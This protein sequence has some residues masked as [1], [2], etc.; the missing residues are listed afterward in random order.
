MSRSGFSHGNTHFDSVGRGRNG[1][2][3]ALARVTAPVATMAISSDAL[4]P[5]YQQER[6]R[7]VLAS[8]GTCV[9]HTVIDSPQ[10]HDGFLLEFD[11]VGAAVSKFLARL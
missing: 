11:Q 5:P 7:D 6:L 4:Y 2:E 9:D 3:A 10:G 8:Q 1:V